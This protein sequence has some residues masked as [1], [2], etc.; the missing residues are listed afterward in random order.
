MYEGLQ[1]NLWV[2]AAFRLMCLF[3]G[4]RVFTYVSRLSVLRKITSGSFKRPGIDQEIPMQTAIEVE[5]LESGW[6]DSTIPDTTNATVLFPCSKHTVIKAQKRT[7]TTQHVFHACARTV[8]ARMCIST[9]MRMFM[10]AC[11]IH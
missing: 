1:N 2:P 3:L 5:G 4:S 9:F 6:S 10:F 8:I 7:A 11:C